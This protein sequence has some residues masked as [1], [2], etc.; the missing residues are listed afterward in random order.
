MGGFKWAGKP[1]THGW[2]VA[3]CV[4]VCVCACVCVCVC[5]RGKIG[6]WENLFVD[7]RLIDDPQENRSID[8]IDRSTT[9]VDRLT[10]NVSAV[11]K[12]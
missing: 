4:C 1:A 12:A 3:V 9:K 11:T 8:I 6:L 7:H 2:L 10:Y 5:V